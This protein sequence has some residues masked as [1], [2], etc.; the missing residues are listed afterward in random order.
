MLSW[1]GV[2]GFVP[3]QKG[4]ISSKDCVSHYPL[5]NHSAVVRVNKYRV[6][7]PFTLC[8]S[9]KG[10]PAEQTPNKPTNTKKNPDLVTYV[11]RLKE[12]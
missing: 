7:I 1:T 11:E 6:S 10:E 8:A 2:S 9:T 3:L 12:V 5:A 4:K